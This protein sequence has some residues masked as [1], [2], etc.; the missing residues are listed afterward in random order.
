MA[1]QPALPQRRVRHGAARQEEER[2]LRGGRE[3][4]GGKGGR[5]RN[6]RGRQEGGEGG[7]RSMRDP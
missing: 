2:H 1:R 4:G 5:F 6:L 7:G 3:K